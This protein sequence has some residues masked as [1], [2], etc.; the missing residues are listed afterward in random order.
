MRDLDGTRAS[1]AEKDRLIKDRDDLLE[2]HIFETRKL[3]EMLD[4]E[5]QAHRNTKIQFDTF[6]KA[7]HHTSRTVSQQEARMQELESSRQNNLKK[8]AQLE[9]SFKEQLTERNNLL[10]A[11]WNK[12][13]AVCGSDWAHNNS[14]INGRALPSLEAVSTMLPGFSKNL[15]AAT[16]M[17]ETIIN[18]FRNQIKTIERDLWKE[19]Q[20]LEST[21][22]ARTKKLDRLETM[23]RSGSA[24][25][26]PE[27]KGQ[28][29]TLKD[30]NRL[31]KVE[32]ASVRNVDNRT[33]NLMDPLSLPSP[34][35]SVPTGPRN[36]PAERTATLTRHHSASTVE[37]MERAT[38][39]MGS[40]AGGRTGSAASG[41]GSGG[42]FTTDEQRWVFR[43]RELEKRLAKEREGRLLDRDG[44]RK[45]LLD[46][47][48]ENEELRKE[49]ERM[50]VGMADTALH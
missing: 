26:G 48:K 14:L 39:S 21:L 5:R 49:L 20:N 3:S 30:A 38:S 15:L 19:Y 18:G 43:L 33:R 11:I 9:S 6:Q 37:T 41:G 44:A 16:K 50:K 4:K 28:L 17:V 29:K 34:S 25:S 32:L 47:K 46:G 1:L 23:V 22:D 27:D 24:S 12:L 8:I 7:H 2:S 42:P 36:K 10:L 13:S 40:S 31:L 45:R 35:P